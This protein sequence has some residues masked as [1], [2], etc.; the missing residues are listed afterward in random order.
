MLAL[1]VVAS[2]V[3]ALAGGALISWTVDRLIGRRMEAMHHVRHRRLVLAT[4]VWLLVLTPAAGIGIWR[5]L[6]QIAYAHAAAAGKVDLALLPGG[7]E[8]GF[9]S[10][11][12]AMTLTAIPLSLW[13]ERA[14]WKG[15][16]AWITF[17][18][19]LALPLASAAAMVD[20][21]VV[22][23][24]NRFRYN[25]FFAVSERSYGYEHVR[26]IRSAP[27]VDSDG[28]P[29]PGREYVIC[30]EDGSAW[31]TMWHSGATIDKGRQL[32]HLVAERSK[33]A[34]TELKRLQRED[35]FCPPAGKGKGAK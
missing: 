8:F 18:V 15:L 6:V 34:I 24:A 13:A 35:E 5:L 12:L 25:P 33:V 4:L 30:F 29:L 20:W 16:S 10:A 32:A 14:E 2:L 22:L 17:I 19:L 26:A 9:A 7:V 11:F 31:S 3:I 27:R 23:T 21:Y 28:N 1:G